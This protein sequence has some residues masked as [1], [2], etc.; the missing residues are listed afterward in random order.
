MDGSLFSQDIRYNNE[1]RGFG[2]LGDVSE[3]K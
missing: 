1:V 2:V 3:K